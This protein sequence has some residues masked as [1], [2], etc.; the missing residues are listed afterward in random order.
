[1]AEQPEKTMDQ[2]IREDGRYPGEAFEF[3]HE[4]LNRAVKEIH[5]EAG[6]DPDAEPAQKHVSGSQ[7]CHALRQEA[8]ERWGMLATTVLNGWKISGTIDFGNM[9]YLLIRN[10]FMRKTDGDSIEDFRDV[11]KFEEAFDAAD[12][13]ELTE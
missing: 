11:Y 6:Q 3:L 13:F 12:H 5:G 1:M 10:N 9:V 7:L 8:I 2:V 4:G